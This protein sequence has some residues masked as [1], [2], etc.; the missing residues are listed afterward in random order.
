MNTK[1][2]ILGRPG[3]GKSTAARHLNARFQRHGWS[4][5]HVNDYDILKRLF[6]EDV[7]HIRF[8]PTPNN[9][10]DA[11]D[12]SVFDTVLHEVE[13]RVI[14]ATTT[15]DLVTIEFARDDYRHAIQQFSSQFLQDAYFLFMN[16]DIET[17]LT[18]VHER[19]QRASGRDDHPSFSDDIFRRY[20]APDNI[21]YIQR[22]MAH[23]FSLPK[24]RILVI[25]NTG[26]LEDSLRQLK[27]FADLIFRETQ[28]ARQP[29]KVLEDC[30]G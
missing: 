12:M 24:Q 16:A 28:D 29:V 2:F 1:V 25:N 27:Q 5:Q 26:L 15:T 23:E 21:K 4:T 10:F 11:I 6:L 3:S 20:Y 7:D 17:C 9:G 14:D 30:V 18:R 22:K 8:R 19:V 13:Q